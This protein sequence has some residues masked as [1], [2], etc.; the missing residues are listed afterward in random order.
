[1][2]R[3][4]LHRIWMGVAVFSLVVPTGLVGQEPPGQYEVGRALP[5]EV[6]GRPTVPMTL[7]E[8][9]ARSLEL[10]LDIQTARLSP[11]IQDYS[12]ASAESVFDW[13]L[14]ATTGYN[15]STNLPTSQLDGGSQVTT[16]RSTYNASIVKPLSWY[17]GR[18]SANFNN[19]RTDTDNSFSTRNPSFSSTLSFSYTQPLLAGLKTDNQRTAIKTQA[20]Q[21]EITDLQLVNRVENIKYQ[22]Y[23]AYWGLRATIEQIEIQ[24]Q[25]L[26]LAQELLAQNR[27]RVSL[28]TMSELQVVQAESQVAAAEQ[29]LLNAEVQWRNQ[30]LAFKSLLVGGAD[31]PLFEQTVNPTDLPVIQEEEVD[32]QAAVDTALDERTDLRQQRRQRQISQLDLAVVENNVLP[33][34]NLS[35]GYSLQGVGG[36]LYARSELGG[37]PVL[38]EEGRYLDGLNSLWKRDAPTWNFSL[39]FSYPIGNQGAKA[40]RERARLQL[41]QE[42]LALRSQELAIVTEVTNAGLAVNDGFLQVMAAQ[43]SR[44]VAERNAEIELTRFRVGAATNYEVTQAQND[45]T[46]A[47][48]SEL[49]ALLNYVNAVAEFDLVQRVGR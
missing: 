32:I 42:D 25:S 21:G 18:L 11:Q 14:G 19:G 35:A 17:G 4:S 16:Q 24:R 3:Q 29:A 9:I 46:F 27:I 26:A 38:I 10:N 20:I 28:G 30:E 8:A 15:N 13:T 48:L 6:E 23:A 45:L 41:Q 34:L 39:N 1:M 2:R 33:D 22:V 44:E 37:D 5:P 7:E 12:L 49:R 36:D 43:R 47:R 40:N 31:D